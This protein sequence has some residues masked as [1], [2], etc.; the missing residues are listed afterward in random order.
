MN[1]NY[2]KG[3]VLLYVLSFYILF[4]SW[5]HFQMKLHIENLL[6]K[7]YINK[8]KTNLEYELEIVKYINNNYPNVDESPSF[9]DFSVKII[10]NESFCEVSILEPITYA[11]IY[12][13]IY[14]E[15]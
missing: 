3:Y 14:K 6:S 10:C 11:F 15:K 8:V 9:N 2:H 7:D 1:S 13:I 5:F 4:M 12:D